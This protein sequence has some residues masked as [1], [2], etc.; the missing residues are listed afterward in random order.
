MQQNIYC[1]AWGANP[2]ARYSSLFLNKLI[3]KSDLCH[4]KVQRQQN[5]IDC[6]CQ[7]FDKLVCMEDF[8]D[9]GDGGRDE[10][11]QWSSCMFSDEMNLT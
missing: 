6:F 1:L 11:I 2:E 10:T 7:K 8:T 4:V 9:V 5:E 3:N